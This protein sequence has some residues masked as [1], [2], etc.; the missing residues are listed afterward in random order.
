MNKIEEALSKLFNMHRII[1]WYDENE[2][3]KEQFNELVLEGIE[4]V[5]VDN[6]QFYIKYITNKVEPN[7]QFLL[8]MPYEKPSNAENWLLD[9]ELA[10]YVFQTKQEAM[11]AQ[12]LEL[13][14][15]FT[16]LIAEHIEFFK[17]KERRAD[18]KQLLGKDDDYLAIRYKMLA[19]LFNTDNVSL[20]SFL[21]VHASAYNDGNERYERELERYNLKGFYWKEISRKYG[22]DSESPS[23]YDFLIEVFNNNYSVGKKT[24]IAKESKILISMWKDSISYQSSYR[25]LSQKIAE[26]LKIESNLNEANL[27]DIIQDDLFEMIDKKIISELANLICDEAISNERLNQLVKQREN[28]Y[29][30]LDYEDFYNCLGA[31]MKMITL[32]RK[33]EKAK[34]ESFSDGINSYVQHLY[35]IDYYYRN[36]IHH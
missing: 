25:K 21:Q 15:N 3:L 35:K 12:E 32:I 4:K 22:Y 2:E 5:V 33:I 24:G 30:Y 31:G 34:V 29:W 36:Y 7:S 19:V 8:Y 11:F 20:V 18:L 23:I 17:S 1:F 28:K 27:D 26:D 14:Y 13:D 16:D 6:N 9:M 10:N